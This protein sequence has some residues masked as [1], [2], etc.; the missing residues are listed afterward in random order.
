MR[1]AHKNQIFQLIQLS[2]DIKDFEMIDNQKINELNGAV[3]RLKN[4]PL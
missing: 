3:I 4:T 2:F 1:R